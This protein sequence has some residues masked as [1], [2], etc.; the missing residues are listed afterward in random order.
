MLEPLRLALLTSG[1][2][3]GLMA[4]RRL[5]RAEPLYFDGARGVALLIF[6]ALAFASIAWSVEPEVTRTTGMELLKL[7]AIY[8]TIINVIT[9]GKRL[10]VMCARWCS[11]RS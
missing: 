6:S 7:T 8:L 11:P 5:G 4:L 3:A 2:A 10:A 9:T 1:V